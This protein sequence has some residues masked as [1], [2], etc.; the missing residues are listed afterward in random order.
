MSKPDYSRIEKVYK[1]ASGV[2]DELAG[3]NSAFMHFKRDKISGTDLGSETSRLE[4]ALKKCFET[5]ECTHV[6]KT[7]SGK[8]MTRKLDAD[9]KATDGETWVYT[10][11]MPNPSNIYGFFEVN[12]PLKSVL[13]GEYAIPASWRGAGDNAKKAYCA[14]TC[15]QVNRN[16]GARC[17]AVEVAGDR[18]YFRDL[19]I[20]LYDLTK[21]TTTLL[22]PI[23][24]TDKTSHPNRGSGSTLVANQLV[25]AFY[26]NFYKAC[27]AGNGE[28][29][30]DSAECEKAGN[31]CTTS[32]TMPWEC[33]ERIGLYA[34]V[35]QTVSEDFNV[36]LTSRGFDEVFDRSE[37]ATKSSLYKALQALDFQNVVFGGGKARL[38]DT[39]KPEAFRS[40]KFP[41][42]EHYRKEKE[43]LQN[44]A[45]EQKV[46]WPVFTIA[47]ALLICG[48]V[49]LILYLVKRKG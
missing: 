7:P 34:Q 6:V 3:G 19:V 39:P 22:F 38:K 23:K 42:P 5:E 36:L 13:I 1:N 21:E 40:E 37:I 44:E 20:D 27:D 12:A 9:Q 16:Q 15:L 18:C 49:C 48:L 28:G 45:L 2:R 25:S 11:R 30:F 31:V 32:G 8:Y 43:R 33:A 29:S 17:H 4:T 35:G 41:L 46:R 47:A 10:D 24:V 14:H 26:E